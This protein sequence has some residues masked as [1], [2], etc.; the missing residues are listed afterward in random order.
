MDH[1]ISLITLAARDPEALAG[2]YEALGWQRADAMEGMVVFDL[3]GQSI[4]IYSRDALAADMGVE[5]EAL[6]HGAMTLAH[7]VGSAE[8]VD[9]L[10]A[11]AEA[12][13]AKILRPGGAV[14]WGGHIG[15]FADPEG[16]VWE[17]AHNPFSPLRS[18]DGAFRWRGY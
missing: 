7:N 4:G 12:A 14:H 2:F 6:G 17:I 18:E 8:E 9:A 11:S 1:R 15:Y 5:P 16:H 3:L 10:M 13:G